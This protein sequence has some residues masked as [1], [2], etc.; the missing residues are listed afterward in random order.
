MKFI[1][2]K[3]CAFLA[4]F[5][6]SFSAFAD[7]KEER[8]LSQEIKEEPPTTKPLTNPRISRLV[9]KVFKWFDE[10]YV[11]MPDIKHAN[12]S[13]LI[14]KYEEFHKIVLK[15]NVGIGALYHRTF[16]PET[17]EILTRTIYILD[18]FDVD[19]PV[20]RSRL[21]HEIDHHIRLLKDEKA[22]IPMTICEAEIYAYRAQRKWL[23]EE[24]RLVPESNAI[25]I[26]NGF[27]SAYEEICSA[28]TE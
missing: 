17:G 27:L 25:F 9:Y 28:E 21:A 1:V 18:T 13:F 15:C 24:E 22:L 19:N 6:L 26:L 3:A 5:V 11:S 4:L 23:L 10:G 8:C 14:R 20:H 7:V 2:H 12:A 16:D